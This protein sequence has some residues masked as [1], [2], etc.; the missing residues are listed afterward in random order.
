MDLLYLFLSLFFTVSSK[1]LPHTDKSLL[2]DWRTVNLAASIV[3]N[4]N[5]R[6]KEMTDLLMDHGGPGSFTFKTFPP[7]VNIIGQSR[8]EINKYTTICGVNCV[9]HPCQMAG[10]AM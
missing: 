6:I 3:R 8:V 9:L 4:T 7:V 5:A 10:W 1:T 2:L